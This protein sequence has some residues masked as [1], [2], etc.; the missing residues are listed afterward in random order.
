M[1]RLSGDFAIPGHEC[2]AS[3]GRMLDCGCCR[4]GCHE[5]DGELIAVITEPS[6][7]SDIFAPGKYAEYAAGDYD[8][9]LQQIRGRILTLVSNGTIRLDEANDVL[10]AAG[11]EEYQ[12]STRWEYGTRGS[13]GAGGWDQYFTTPGSDQDEALAL[14]RR[15]WEAFTAILGEITDGDS[16]P[17]TSQSL[18]VSEYEEYED[19]GRIPDIP[20]DQLVPLL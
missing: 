11:L 1:I 17:I 15:A 5:D 14:F 7:P 9:R 10:R 12:G 3:C 13:T 6:L 20:A 16:E 18:S 4:E 19:D 8:K 2:S